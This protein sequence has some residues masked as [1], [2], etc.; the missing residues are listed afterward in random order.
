MTTLYHPARTSFGGGASGAFAH[1][2][3]TCGASI[4]MTGWRGG[5]VRFAP[6]V[7]T[8]IARRH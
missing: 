2:V 3:H 1:A 6:V 5:C 7:H 8:M 4:Y